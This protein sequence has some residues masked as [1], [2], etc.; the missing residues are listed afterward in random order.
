MRTASSRVGLVAAALMA[1]GCF[2]PTRPCTSDVDCVA[3]GR[4]DPG[5][6]T[7]VSRGNPN[8]TTPPVFSIVIAPPGT[9]QNTAK[10]TELDPGSPDG[11]VDAFRRDETVVVTVTSPDT[12]VDGESVQLL[13]YGLSSNPVTA[14]QAQLVPC[15]SGTPLA[16][17]PFCR[18]ATVALGPLPFDAFRGVM[19]LEASGADLSDNH[20]KVDSGINVTRWKWKYSAGAPIYTT[21]AIADD[22]T[23]VFG[24]S[25]GGSGSLYAL[26]PAGAE[27]WAPLIMGPIRAS[28][29][30]GTSDAGQQVLYVAS[31]SPNAKVFAIDINDGASLTS[32]PPGT[33]T[34]AGPFL[35]TPAIVTSGSGPFE[36]A[37]ALASGTKL[38]NIRP[39]ASGSDPTCITTDTPGT[40]AFASNVVAQGTESFLATAEGLVR[41]FTLDSGNWIKNTGWGG[42][43]G[44]VG[45]GDR[46][47][48]A[49]TLTSSAVLGTTSLRGVFAL[50]RASG[51]L[52]SSFPIGGLSS[53]PGGLTIGTT[54]QIF[55]SGFSTPAV[56]YSVAPDG[57]SGSS[58]SLPEPLTGTP[59]AGKGG[60]IYI[61]TL[62]GTLEARS[63]A[64]TTVWA[65][66]LGANESFLASPTIGC[67]DQSPSQSASLL[68]AAVTGNIFSIVVD[69]PGLDPTAAWP[70]YQH[71]IRNTGNPSTPI[72]SCP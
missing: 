59:L 5:T 70:K 69:S 62:G 52:V 55:G 34:Y 16:S 29:V 72:Q 13:V 26:T 3:G 18:Q 38:V 22:G 42:G 25:D 28:P 15:A 44:Y 43:L 61:A 53:D 7:C 49:V 14:F 40:Q 4:C 51:T 31:A 47:V 67:G 8:D 2:D 57:S 23:I 65:Q 19:A 37:L 12:D 21:P 46:A 6:K 39:G 24:T 1:G 20:G 71:D 41:A 27:K 48:Q 68:L 10:L 56:L 17:N 50:A 33:A 54:E 30:I 32:C 66:S 45:V 63:G 36:G 58:H 64:S 60:L 35:G 9:R 11:G